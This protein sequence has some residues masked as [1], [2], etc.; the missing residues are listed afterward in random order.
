MRVLRGARCGNS[1]R[2]DLRGGH[3]AIGVPTSISYGDR[4]LL[5]FSNLV[6]H[7]CLEKTPNVLFIA[8]DVLNDWAGYRGRKQVMSPRM[9][10]L[11]REGVWFS[12]GYCQY[13]VCGA[14]R[15]SL[16]S[17]LH[18]H[19][20][21]SKKLQMKD[22]M[23]A[24]RAQSKG[25]R[26]LHAYFIRDYG[27][28]TMEVGKILHKHLLK[29]DLDESGGRGGWDNHVDGK[30]PWRVE[31]TESKRVENQSPEVGENPGIFG[32]TII[33]LR[34]PWSSLDSS[35]TTTLPSERFFMSATTMLLA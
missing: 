23:V 1:A 3:R 30:V 7:P 8:V 11:A 12:K 32:M 21:D 6:F 17:S 26:L 18:F 27:Y 19:Q 22:T 35:F 15:A 31:P 10:E 4:E 16:M 14:S 2:R 25:S 24:V 29:K 20:L 13:P 34:A 33:S 28:K 9:D 5:L